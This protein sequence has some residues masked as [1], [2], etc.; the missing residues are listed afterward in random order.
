MAKGM[1]AP[2][3]AAAERRLIEAAAAGDIT[4]EPIGDGALWKRV[5]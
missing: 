5:R 4:R 3:R 1:V 2:D